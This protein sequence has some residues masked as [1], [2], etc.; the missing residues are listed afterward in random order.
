MSRWKKKRINH[1]SSERSILRRTRI[2]ESAWIASTMI[3][4]FYLLL[5]YLLPL[6][7]F[8]ISPSFQFKFHMEILVCIAP[9]SLSAIITFGR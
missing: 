8:A 5:A 9:L 6:A 2:I 1:D 7:N 4:S 3:G